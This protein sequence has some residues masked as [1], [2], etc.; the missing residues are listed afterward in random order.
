MKA[1]TERLTAMDQRFTERFDRMETNIERILQVQ[2]GAA[3]GID[4]KAT[5]RVE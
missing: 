3:G 4:N 1:L 2:L 5:S